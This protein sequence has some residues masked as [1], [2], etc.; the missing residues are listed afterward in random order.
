MSYNLFIGWW[1]ALVGTINILF[2]SY[3]WGNKFV[4]QLG[5]KINL[6][7]FLY[8]FLL[9]LLLTV[10]IFL[11]TKFTNSQY[12]IKTYYSH[13]I[14]IIHITFY[15][16]NEEMILGSILLNF[17]KRKFKNLHQAWVSFYI[18]L[19]FVILHYIIYRWVFIYKG[20]LLPLTLLSLL[21]IG[22]I[23][24]NLILTTNHIGFSWALHF[25]WSAV[26]F[27]GYHFSMVSLKRI[28]DFEL[29]N[30]HMGS[31]MVCTVTM[32]LSNIRKHLFNTVFFI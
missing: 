7:I 23:R 20:I 24:N 30:L 31:I 29:F 16:L 12:N 4:D 11:F 10:G 32:C 5:L 28:K 18:A 17:I 8:S 21:A 13:W 22:I 2:L 9:A 27:G 6:K 3:L 15:S 26:M 1:W 25:S 14:Y 19:I